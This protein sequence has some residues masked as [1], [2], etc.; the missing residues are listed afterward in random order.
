MSDDGNVEGSTFEE[1]LADLEGIVAELDRGQ[2]TL[3]ESLA[4]FEKGVALLRRCR[5]QLDGAE[6]RLMELIEIDAQGVAHLRPLAHAS[7]LSEEA[8]RAKSDDST[9]S[10]EEPSRPKRSPSA[11][12]SRPA[13]QDDDKTLF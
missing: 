10:V 8:A 7:S 13:A 12:T 4:Y 1:A 6:A 3:E 11:R 5:R 2:P 9:S